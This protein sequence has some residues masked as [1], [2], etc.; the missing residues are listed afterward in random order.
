MISSA[1]QAFQLLSRGEDAILAK[2]LKNLDLSIETTKHLIPMIDALKNHE[3]DSAMREYAL[4][5]ELE[6]KADSLHLSTVNEVSS[7]SFFGGIR[8]DILALL[9]DIE[10]IADSAKDCARIFQQRRMADLTLDYFF[11]EDISFFIRLCIDAEE[12][13]A[14]IGFSTG[15]KQIQSDSDSQNKLR[16]RRKRQMLSE[17]RYS[18]IS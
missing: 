9:G 16:R 7:G 3:Y 4:I 2:L 5:S 14:R 11:V 15:K 12:L 13:P 18:K 6:A 17:Q 1:Q 8:E 10:N